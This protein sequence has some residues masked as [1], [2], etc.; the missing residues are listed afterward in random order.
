MEI[1]SGIIRLPMSNKLETFLPLLY[2]TLMTF[3]HSLVNASIA[4][5]ALFIASTTSSL[6][7][8]VGCL[9]VIRVKSKKI[10]FSAILKSNQINTSL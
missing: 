8:I 3:Y 10:L 2:K 9:L 5:A 1:F 4:S 7:L 6:V